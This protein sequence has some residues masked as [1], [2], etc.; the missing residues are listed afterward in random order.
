[1]LHNFSEKNL[2]NHNKLRKNKNI[3]AS[4]S[5]FIA[6]LLHACIHGAMQIS[7]QYFNDIITTSFNKNQLS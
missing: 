1:M 4:A 3:D 5:E 6:I 2:I 7:V